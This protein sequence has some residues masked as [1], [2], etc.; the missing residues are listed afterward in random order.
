[1]KHKICQT[2][3]CSLILTRLDAECKVVIL[4]STKQIDNLYVNKHTNGLS[5][6]LNSTKNKYSGV[7]LFSIRLSKVLRGP[8]T[9]WA[10]NIFS[11]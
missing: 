1:M 10:E 2:K 7:N 3:L 9:E 5:T 11:K 8:I 4:G 6:I